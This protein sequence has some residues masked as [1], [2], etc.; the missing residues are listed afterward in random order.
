MKSST[1]A[2]T[3]ITVPWAPLRDQLSV[4][5]V[6]LS[7][8]QPSIQNKV[9]ARSPLTHL[10]TVIIVPSTTTVKEVLATD[11]SIHVKMA[12]YALKVV[13]I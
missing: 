13:E 5:P 9:L 4:W 7:M 1:D 3:V 6:R 2:P 8:R 10:M 11:S 12:S